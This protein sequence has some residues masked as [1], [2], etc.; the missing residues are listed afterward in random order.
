ML[1]QHQLVYEI[2]RIHRPVVQC[3]LHYVVDTSI[4]PI[5]SNSVLINCC[6][7]VV[8]DLKVNYFTNARDQIVRKFDPTGLYT[9]NFVCKC[10]KIAG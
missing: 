5:R 4:A 7:Q 10:A 6:G 1:F 2:R 3:P 8:L 9:D